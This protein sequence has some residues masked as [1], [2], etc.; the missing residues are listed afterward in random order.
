MKGVRLT[1]RA[2][3][4]LSEIA[5]WTYE[6]FGARQADRYE[7]ELLERVRALAR[8]EVIARSCVALLPRDSPATDLQ[9]FRVQRHYVI[10][11]ERETET[12]ILD[13]V[14]TSRDLEAI[15]SELDDT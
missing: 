1:R 2:E 10:F 7:A 15:L 8:G 3:A 14:H 5:A 9:Y 4:R 11:V 6:R 12:V 13:F